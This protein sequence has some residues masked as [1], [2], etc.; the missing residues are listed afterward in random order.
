MRFIHPASSAR[1]RPPPRFI[2]DRKG[3]GFCRREQ[4]EAGFFLSLLSILLSSG[5]SGVSRGSEPGRKISSEREM[6]LFD[7]SAVSSTQD[8]FARI[9]KDT[10]S[11]H[12][13]T[14]GVYSVGNPQI[15]QFGEIWT[16]GSRRENGSRSCFEFHL[17]NF[18][19]RKQSIPDGSRNQVW[20]PPSKDQKITASGANGE[21]SG[22]FRSW[23]HR[24]LTVQVRVLPGPQA[25]QTGLSRTTR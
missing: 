9:K 24:D 8:P 23:F 1:I 7:S 18:R 5:L 10:F 3:R 2:V 17:S 4:D 14:G 22:A 6:T 13:H 21:P 20:V 11:P 25:P 15:P 19:K 12:T 16:E